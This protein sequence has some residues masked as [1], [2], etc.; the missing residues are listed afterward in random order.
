MSSAD[1]VSFIK[2]F[3]R[4]NTSIMQ[5]MHNV[6]QGGCL[7]RFNISKWLLL[8]LAGKELIQINNTIIARI[9]PQCSHMRKEG[10]SHDLR[11]Y[12]AKTDRE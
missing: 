9:L 4:K 6:L 2:F 7:L 8:L 5:I 1:F 3:F 11:Q 12:V 10:I